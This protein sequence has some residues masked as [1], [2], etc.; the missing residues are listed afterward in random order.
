MLVKNEHRGNMKLNEK[1]RKLRT[2]K[3]LTQEALAE[4]L[5]VSRQAI[6]KWEKGEG[7]PDIEN[8]TQISRFFGI[9]IDELVKEE[10][11]IKPNGIYAYTW[12][13]SLA[14]THSKRLELTAKNIREITLTGSK[15]DAIEIEI[16]SNEVEHLEE[17]IRIKIDDPK[18]LNNRYQ[19]NINNQENKKSVN[20]KVT[21]PQKLIEHVEIKTHT[22]NMILTEMKLTHLEVDGEV[23]YVKAIHTKGYIV[24]NNGRS[25]IDL[26]FDELVEK[27]D[28]NLISSK[29]TLTIPETSRYVTY[30]KGRWTTIEGNHDTEKATNEIELNGLTS[31][32]MILTK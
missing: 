19:L 5:N 3:Q 32:L 22:Q 17:S 13:K 10:Q 27:L 12:K 20:L 6:T 28:I 24:F 25:D 7:I 31:K 26:E 23:R 21:I 18:D 29:A 4:K 9:T 2:Q 1:L 15:E 11:E 16:S 8:I 14:L 30:N